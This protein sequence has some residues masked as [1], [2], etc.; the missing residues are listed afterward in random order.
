MNDKLFLKLNKLE[1]NKIMHNNIR[2][3]HPVTF[4]SVDLHEELFFRF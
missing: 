2:H 1:L 3:R 4:V